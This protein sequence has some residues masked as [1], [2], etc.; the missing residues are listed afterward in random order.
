MPYGL[1]V[2]E[3]FSIVETP[4][5]DDFAAAVRAG[6]RRRPRR[7]P[8]RFFYD[9]RGSELFEKICL[10]PEYYVTRTEFAILERCA[11]ELPP[12]DTVIE[13]GCG[14]GAKTRLLFEALFRKRRHITFVPVDISRRALEETGRQLTAH[15][16]GLAV[17]AIQAEF[18]DAFAL[19]PRERSL[20]L[21]LG[22]NIG[23]LDHAEA[24]RFLR[25]LRGHTI[26]VGLDMQKDPALLHAAYDDSQGVTAAFN[27]NL[28]ARINR[29]LGGDFDLARW[30]HLAL[31]DA[32][33]GRVEMHLVSQR[34]QSVRVLGERH[35]FGAEERI[36]TENSYKFSEDQIAALA[37][38]SG[39]HVERRWTDV[40]GWFS[41]VLLS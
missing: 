36:H 6:L 37:A 39:L 17:R 15:Y 20:V 28:L 11:A 30:R 40:R 9:A 12:A 33:A 34:S 38:A 19:I 29:E 5:R 4:I 35:V 26:L 27:L 23:N 2:T 22:S 24:V 14:Y 25:A 31:Y 13:F 1:D 10:L 32:A 3:R 41:V 18:G 16:P 21:F 7:I 8:P